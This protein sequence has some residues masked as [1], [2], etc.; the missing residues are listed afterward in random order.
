MS[1]RRSTEGVGSSLRRATDTTRGAKNV[2]PADRYAG[3]G[4]VDPGGHRLVTFG[5]YFVESDSERVWFARDTLGPTTHM[6][7]EVSEA[8][9][10]R[11]TRLWFTCKTCRDQ[12]LAYVSTIAMPAVTAE[13]DKAWREGASDNTPKR[14]KLATIPSAEGYTVP[15]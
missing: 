11:W 15:E 1:R 13:V 4:L 14:R 7:Y 9:H 5:H 3:V 12:G 6:E 8:D 2:F 10:D